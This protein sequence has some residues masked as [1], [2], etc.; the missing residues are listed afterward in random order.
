M[1][2][3][4]LVNNFMICL[5]VSYRWYSLLYCSAML[6]SGTLNTLEIILLLL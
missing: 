6:N 5:A 4:D 2:Y 3:Y 1:Y